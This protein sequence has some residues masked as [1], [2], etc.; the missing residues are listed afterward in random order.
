MVKVV[1]ADVGGDGGVHAR[2][3][4]VEDALFETF[5]VNGEVGWGSVGLNDVAEVVGGLEDAEGVGV[6]IGAGDWGVF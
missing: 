5:V 4:A 6:D 2:D 1:G 3:D